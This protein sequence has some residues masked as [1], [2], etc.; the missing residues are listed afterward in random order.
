MFRKIL[1]LWVLVVFVS[2][3]SD[4]KE[5]EVAIAESNTEVE[6]VQVQENPLKDAYFG[7]EHLHTGV[8]M[9][10]FIAGT[11][12]GPDDA[13]KFAKGEKVKV[14]GQMHQI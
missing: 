9:D 10:A 14:N 8:S 12:I 4:K 1:F 5:P 11:R 6:P 2:C 13:Y 7:E 3:K